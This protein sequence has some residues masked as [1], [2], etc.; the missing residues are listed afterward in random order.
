MKD[1]KFSIIAIHVLKGT[2]ENIRKVLKENEWYFFK[3]YEVV[4]DNNE[5]EIP[6]KN[7]KYSLP[8]DFFGKNITV[9]AIVG[10]NGSGKST[11]IDIFLMI[12][13]NLCVHLS[14]IQNNSEIS[15]QLVCIE[16]LKA[17]LYYSIEG[18]LYRVSSNGNIVKDKDGT[19]TDYGIELQEYNNNTKEWKNFNPTQLHSTFF[20]TVLMNYALRA[21]NSDNYKNQHN[22]E[23]TWNNTWLHKIFKH[24]VETDFN[25]TPV[26]IKPEREKGNI[27]VNIELYE[28][29]NKLL[30]LFIDIEGQETTFSKIT[31]EYKAI[32]FNI[33]L[34]KDEID[35]KWEAFKND[36][37]DSNFETDKGEPYKGNKI[38]TP[39]FWRD[40]E[41]H[42]AELWSKVLK[43][44][45]TED[46]TEKVAI[47]FLV[48]ETLRLA[49]KMLDKN[50]PLSLTNPQQWENIQWQKIK[51]SVL[52]ILKEFNIVITPESLPLRQTIAYLKNHHTPVGE[53]ILMQ[54]FS[55]SIV[56]AM[57]N[58][59][60][61][62]GRYAEEVFRLLPSP[63]FDVEI[64]LE[65]TEK[66]TVAIDTLI[67]F[68]NLSSGEQQLIFLSSSIL[69]QIRE[70]A[71]LQY[72]YVN[73][74]LDEI[75][76]YFHPEYQ[77]RFVDYLIQSIKD[78]KLRDI[79]GINIILSTH[80][81]F[82][83]SD[84]PN[85]N[86]MYLEEGKQKKNT[87]MP[88]TFSANIHDLLNNAF[89]LNDTMGEFAKKQIKSAIKWLEQDKPKENEE[90][91]KNK[92]WNFI[93]LIGEPL[94]KNSLK[95]WYFKHFPDKEMIQKEIERLNALLEEN[96]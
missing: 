9:S 68:S 35:S 5:N 43:I 88:E 36:W 79:E 95:G 80:S 62:I 48:L 94:I 29:K 72:K 15:N 67:P 82:I 1:D 77:R 44:T 50:P 14:H 66:N 4:K 39:Q 59:I 40:L 75:E 23:V 85:C 73:I 87:D 93:N 18:K 19:V 64:H 56:N 63:I 37:Q 30:S 21:L 41:N 52:D 34:A 38:Y 46:E 24:Q 78:M 32:G 22:P 53:K 17:E 65:K 42:L 74:I 51:H 7:D 92:I 76:L 47:K 10:K 25:Q 89:F 58:K 84:I 27:D 33:K 71:F 81:P 11:I 61:L 12:V 26:I 31:P 55:S 69:Y 54:V 60:R 13:N 45:Y 96:K 57:K 6:K 86:I 20:Y 49:D 16:E 83:L 8:D 3:S 90:W 70:I 91:D 28:T 2:S